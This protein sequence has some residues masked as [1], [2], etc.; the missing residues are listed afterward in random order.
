[1]PVT[2]QTGR[3]FNDADEALEFI[4]SCTEK[5]LDPSSSHM[6]SMIATTEMVYAFKAL[7]DHLLRGGSLPVAWRNSVR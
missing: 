2:T 4:R 5:M 1:M 7:D 6:D 3:H